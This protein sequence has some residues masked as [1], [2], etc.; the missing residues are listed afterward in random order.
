VISVQNTGDQRCTGAKAAAFA[1]ERT[2]P[3]KMQDMHKGEKNKKKSGGN[4]I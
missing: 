3:E 4:D 1:P 2:V